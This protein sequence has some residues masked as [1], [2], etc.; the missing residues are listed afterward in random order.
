[1]IVGKLK[2]PAQIITN[3]LKAGEKNSEI[4]EERKDWDLRKWEQED[5]KGLEEIRI[6][7]IELYKTMYKAV[8]KVDYAD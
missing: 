1:M 6:N 7:N 3:Q 8:Y 5:E 4:P 2:T